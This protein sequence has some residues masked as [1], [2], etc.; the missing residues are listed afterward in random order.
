MTTRPPRPD[1]ELLDDLAAYA[2]DALDDDE[3]LAVEATLLADNGAA[4]IS[5]AFQSAAVAYA[6]ATAQP[7]LRTEAPPAELR[8]R[9]LDAAFDRRAPISTVAAGVV[10]THM[11]ETERL[12]LLVRRL[13]LEQFSLPLDPPEFAGWT[14]RDLV[15]HL[16]S[17]EALLA[18]VAGAPIDVP[19]RDNSNDTRTAAVIA[20][21]QT[22]TIDESIAEYRAARLAV[23]RTVRSLV[24]HALDEEI[25][26]WGMPMRLRDALVLRA[27]E[28][29]THAD[30]VRRA[31]G[32]AAAPPSAPVLKRMSSAAVEWMP[33]AISTTGKDY[34]D[35]SMVIDLTGPGGE[36]YHID[37][38][39]AGRSLESVEPDAVLR[40]DA[41]VFCQAIGSRAW[42][43]E[44]ELPIEA[45]GERGLAED[46]I[47]NIDALAVL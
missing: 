44:G 23:D 39:G 34:R 40:I 29:W 9:V 1:N 27:F 37:L 45:E 14:V 16:C 6:T 46:L 19:E 2:T 28:T 5:A 32:L 35:R 26:W 22:M 43:Y 41:V 20:R 3:H 12:E 10:D 18:Q 36:R 7:D 8:A 15:A 11:I 31:V 33:L 17:N 21:H 47:A 4:A 42:L 13:T 24:E 38:S 25:E 30:D